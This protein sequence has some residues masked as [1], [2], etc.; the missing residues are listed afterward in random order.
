MSNQNGGEVLSLR[1]YRSYIQ[2][3]DWLFPPQCAG[4]GKPGSHWCPESQVNLRRLAGSHCFSCGLP[5]RQAELCDSCLKRKPT[6]N[7]ARSY[8]YYE[9]H[10]RS[11]L[12]NAK[13]RRDQALGLVFAQFLKQLLYD[14]KWDVDAV[15]P[16]PLSKER[17]RQRGYNQVELFARP[18]ALMKQFEYRPMALKRIK[19]TQSQV[20][21]SLEARWHNLDNAFE[22]K[23]EMVMAKKVLLLDD[24]MT[25]GA[26]LSAASDALVTAGA[27]A[28]YCLTVART[29]SRGG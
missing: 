11:A 28:V 1:V 25:T 24:V 3:L 20:G 21:L 23:P 12:L 27:Q 7:R 8:A 17:L 5:K 2:A 16:I 13:Y 19:E 26:T 18:L 15:V 14:Q 4:C 6:Y 10:L 22:A 9:G 29:V